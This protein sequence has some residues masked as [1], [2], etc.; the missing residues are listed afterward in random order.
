MCHIRAPTS[1]GM[2]GRASSRRSCPGSA[3][4]P[5]YSNNN[6]YPVCSFEASK[7]KEGFQICQELA[8]PRRIQQVAFVWRG[9]WQ[10]EV[11]VLHEARE[12]W[13]MGH[14]WHRQFQVRNE[15]ILNFNFAEAGVKRWHNSVW[16]KCQF[17]TH[18]LNFST[19]QFILFFKAC[20][21]LLQ[22]LS[23]V[24][25]VNVSGCNHFWSIDTTILC[26]MVI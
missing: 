21:E 4:K 18:S 22:R 19:W 15:N 2:P 23:I 26:C 11:Q 8:E 20:P 7:E 16:I 17:Y 25:W 1:A 14:M 6:P 12:K 24:S 9:D 10:N 3:G 5:T 13:C